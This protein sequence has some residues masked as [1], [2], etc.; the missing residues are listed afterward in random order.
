MTYTVTSTNDNIVAGS[1]YYFKLRALNSKGY[2]EFSTEILVG[3]SSLPDAPSAPYK[4]ASKSTMTQLYIMWDPVSD[5]SL[6]TS[7]YKLY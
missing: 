5:K 4:I 7:G 2:S 1:K 6:P 3:A